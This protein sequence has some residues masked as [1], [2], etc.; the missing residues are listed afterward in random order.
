MSLITKMFL[1]DAHSLVA[2]VAPSKV[3]LLLR[4]ATLHCAAL[5]FRG[6]TQEL[7]DASHMNGI[8]CA[9]DKKGE[10]ACN[11]LAQVSFVTVEGNQTIN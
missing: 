2:K 6:A 5:F 4:D 11:H 8:Y 3:D 10:R 7:I 1:P 9:S